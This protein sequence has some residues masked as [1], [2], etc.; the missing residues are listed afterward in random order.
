MFSME[1][2][3]QTIQDLTN[4]TEVLNTSLE[5]LIDNII[6]SR[7]Q[8]VFSIPSLNEDYQDVRVG[9]D[10]IVNPYTYEFK[11]T[12]IP[13]IEFTPGLNWNISYEELTDDSVIYK[14][15][16]NNY[17]SKLK[18]TY[19]AKDSDEPVNLF[20]SDSVNSFNDD[21]IVSVGWFKDNYYTKD[22]SILSVFPVLSRP[23]EKIEDQSAI[24][25][26]DVER[27]SAVNLLTSEVNVHISGFVNIND[28]SI[29]PNN[30]GLLNGSFTIPIYLKN[31]SVEEANSIDS[32]ITYDFLHNHFIYADLSNAKE[33]YVKTDTS[34]SDSILDTTTLGSVLS[35]YKLSKGLVA[36]SSSCV[37]NY[38]T[39]PEIPAS[40]MAKVLRYFNEEIDDYR[41]LITNSQDFIHLLTQQ[42]EEADNEL[43]TL[44]TIKALIV[45]FLNKQSPGLI[46]TDEEYA[47]IEANKSILIPI[48]Q[49]KFEIPVVVAQSDACSVKTL[50]G[51]LD[52]VQ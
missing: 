11:F 45:L 9:F 34:S 15:S 49:N 23:L 19:L 8:A 48:D 30:F 46:L 52:G 14:G 50:K 47:K 43:V 2:L 1:E 24:T 3:N 32:I 21:E 31:C 39:N 4:K 7:K 26:S 35:T 16:F 29:A 18:E 6:E 12:S 41:N 27:M 5:T 20:Y 42:G 36:L 28:L 33:L 44:S 17:L 38:F 37:V 25:Y 51:I 13:T 40:P 10:L 22:T